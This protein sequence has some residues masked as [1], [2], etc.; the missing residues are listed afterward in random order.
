M[1]CAAAVQNGSPQQV[2]ADEA[3]VVEVEAEVE[4]RH[5]DDGDA[6]QRVEAVEARSRRSRLGL[7]AGHAATIADGPCA[8]ASAGGGRRSAE[9]AEL[10]PGGGRD[11]QH[12]DGEGGRRS[13]L[14][15][16][17]VLPGVRIH[18]LGPSRTI[19]PHIP[20]TE[21]LTAL[22]EKKAT[23]A[24]SAKPTDAPTS[25]RVAPGVIEAK[26]PF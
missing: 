17:P 7:R 10:E 20:K 13:R 21:L 26:V 15:E 25:F 11:G 22:L 8:P 12:R 6:A 16:T 18:V 3:E 1:R 5:P 24:R 23:T 2:L 4:D 19:R 9:A 14:L